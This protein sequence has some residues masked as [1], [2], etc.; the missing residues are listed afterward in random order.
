[1]FLSMRDLEESATKDLSAF[2]PP[3][4][5]EPRSIDAP[6]IDVVVPTHP[7]LQRCALDFP[8]GSGE[9]QKRTMSATTHFAHPMN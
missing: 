4:Q 8:G 3:A 1:M 9:W 5:A 6:G 2:P 7:A